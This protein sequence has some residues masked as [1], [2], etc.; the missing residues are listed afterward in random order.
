MN[1]IRVAGD[2]E[3]ARQI[4]PAVAVV[5]VASENLALHVDLS[6]ALERARLDAVLQRGRGDHQLEARTHV[7]GGKR[8]VDKRCVRL[9]K[10]RRHVVRI[11]GR[12]ADSRLD[13]AGVAVHHHH[14]ALVVHMLFGGLFRDLLDALVQREHQAGLRLGRG[15]DHLRRLPR[16]RPPGGVHRVAHLDHSTVFLQKI[17]V[18]LLDTVDSDAVLQMADHMHRSRDRRIPPRHLKYPHRTVRLG[19][20]GRPQHHRLLL[21]QLLQKRLPVGHQALHGGN[22][23]GARQDRGAVLHA[24]IDQRH[25]VAVVDHPPRMRHLQRIGTL[26]AR[27]LGEAFPLTE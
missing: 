27:H 3:R 26:A 8:L 14:G 9:F 25:K 13:R 23:L 16:E 19:I 20:S 22:R 17:V 18:R 12:Q 21:L 15:I 1:E 24:R 7:E 11:K 4:H 10:A 2:L 5:V 6:G